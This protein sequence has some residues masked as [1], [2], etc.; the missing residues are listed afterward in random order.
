QSL[1]LPRGIKLDVPKGAPVSDE[2]LADILENY[3][4]RLRAQAAAQPAAS[5]PTGEP[6]TRAS[7]FRTDDQT[8]PTDGAAAVDPGANGGAE[9]G[10]VVG[11]FP[12]RRFVSLPATLLWQPPLAN[13]YE[14]RMYVKACTLH[15]PLFSS[16]ND[17]NLGG[18]LAL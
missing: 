1:E 8:G 7:G 14:P 18:T 15:N 16:V 2:E 11:L 12:N 9:P 4:R 3:A 10:A 13:P 6:A 17:F 5:P